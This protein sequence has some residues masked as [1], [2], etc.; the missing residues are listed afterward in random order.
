MPSP[1]HLAAR[2]GRVVTRLAILDEV[3]DGE[4]DLRSNAIDVHVA[5]LRAKVDRHFDAPADIQ[6]LVAAWDRGWLEVVNP[7]L[8]LEAVEDRFAGDATD[9]FAFTTR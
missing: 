8:R 1:P 7:G 9:R 4:A 2:A 5:K 3:W 6:W